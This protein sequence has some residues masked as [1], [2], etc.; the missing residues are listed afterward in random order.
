M[1]LLS[2]R[3]WVIGFACVLTALPSAAAESSS[4]S[5][6]VSNRTEF[7]VQ[8][9][10]RMDVEPRTKTEFGARIETVASNPVYPVPFNQSG[11][12]QTLDVAELGPKSAPYFAVR[13]AL[14]IPPDN[15]TNL[16][17]RL[18]GVDPSVWAHNH[19]PGLQVL[20]NG[21]VLA[22]YFSALTPRG[23][24]ERS[25]Q[26]R[27][28]QA[29]LRHGSEE[30]DFPELFFNSRDYNDQS[31]LLWTDGLTVRFFGGGRENPIPFK[32]AHSADNGAS[33]RFSLP[34]LDKPPVDYTAQPIANAFRDPK[35]AMYF[36]MDAQKDNSFLW[37]S[38][39]RGETWHD[40]G[41][42]TGGRHSTIVPLKDG[43][44]LLS[45]GGKNTAINGFNPQNIS[46]NWG[47]TWSE[48][49]PTI[50][51]PLGGNQ[52]PSQIRLA[53]GD[54]CMVTDSYHR[55]KE[56]PPDGWIDGAGCFVAISKDDGATWR[57]KRLPVELPHEEDRARGTLGY[58][59]VAQAPNGMIHVLA[60]MTQ[61]C[62]H[63]EF[64]E[65]WVY[66]DAGEIKPQFIDGQSRKFV[67]KYPNGKVRVTWSAKVFKNGR[68]V[69]DGTETSYYENGQKEHEVKYANGRKFGKETFWSPDGKKVWSWERRLKQK[70][71]TWTHYWPNGRKRIES[72]WN[73]NPEARDVERKFDGYEAHGVATHW[74]ESGKV[75]A[76]Y[77]FEQGRLVGK[78]PVRLASEKS[79]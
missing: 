40:M 44:T 9:G 78:P 71:A 73:L 1:H 69:L 15:D 7:V 46:T 27:F 61:P 19:S 3:L 4:A 59:T 47:E 33:W 68:Y 18:A 45:I 77:R 21:D 74:D 72:N 50:F 41:G 56:S 17:G 63:Y 5:T 66:S 14:P 48:S 2:K 12:K 36:A 76:E 35:G 49:R 26:A 30:W 10:G 54:L 42:R 57:V 70:N 24:S 58:G 13:F 38:T 28:V 60:T 43:W 62:L 6:G 79:F 37:R 31:A 23:A 22:I 34:K 51:S 65:A 20:P 75:I 53:N 67:E 8:S 52:R 29:R 32:M 16:T 11:I 55:K 64:N 39:D 25:P